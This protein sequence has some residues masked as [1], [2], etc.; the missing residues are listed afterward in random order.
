MM[1]KFRKGNALVLVTIVMFA[2]SV[3]AASL[4]M[5]FAFANRVAEKNSRYFNKRIE[6]SNEVNHNYL[7]LLEGENST[8]EAKIG[9]LSSVGD[10]ESFILNGYQSEVECSDYTDSENL[11]FVYSISSDVS[12]IR[13]TYSL[14]LI[15]DSNEYQATLKE[16]YTTYDLS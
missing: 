2:V 7:L 6:L 10:K 12:N 4:T 14:Q 9:G 3:I 8:L 13:Y 11:S 15:L 16:A 5:Y 1:A